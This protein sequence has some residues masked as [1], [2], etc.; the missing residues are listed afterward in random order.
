MTTEQMRAHVI[1]R[2]RVQGVFFRVE[3]QRAA[4]EIGVT[5]WVRNKSDGTVEAVMEGDQARVTAMIEWCGK[6][7][8]MSAVSAVDVKWE[9]PS[10]EHE[11][12]RIVG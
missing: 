11:G 5:G 12:F 9:T 1:I 10:G 3:T 2:G 4:R 6:G 8:P 7:S